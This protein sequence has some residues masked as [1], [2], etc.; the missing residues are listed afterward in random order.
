M[1][2]LGTM[3]MTSGTETLELWSKSWRGAD[4]GVPVERTVFARALC[5]WMSV[6]LEGSVTELQPVRA[7]SLGKEGGSGPCRHFLGMPRTCCF[8]LGQWEST[9]G[10]WT[11]FKGVPLGKDQGQDLTWVCM[12]RLILWQGFRHI[13]CQLSWVFYC[14]WHASMTRNSFSSLIESSFQCVPESVQF[15]VQRSSPV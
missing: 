8:L 7:E 14:N 10:F 3:K 5:W 6:P 15:I 9:Q 12:S 13:D 1:I 2:I 11:E 4:W